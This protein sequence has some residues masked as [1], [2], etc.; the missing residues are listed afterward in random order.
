VSDGDLYLQVADELMSCALEADREGP[1][2]EIFVTAVLECAYVTLQEWVE[3]RDRG[4][5]GGT[6]E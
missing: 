6:H 4:T 5:N 3:A 2:N 1:Q